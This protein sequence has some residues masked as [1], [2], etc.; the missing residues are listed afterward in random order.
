MA[1][2]LFND[3]KRIVIYIGAVNLIHLTKRA[4]GKGKVGAWVRA[5]IERELFR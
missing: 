1:K 2:K 4:G 5:L 3:R